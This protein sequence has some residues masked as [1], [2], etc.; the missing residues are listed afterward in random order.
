MPLTRMVGKGRF[1][2]ILGM[3][4]CIDAAICDERTKAS[5]VFLIVALHIQ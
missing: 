2:F 5:Q 1:G 3:I 4:S